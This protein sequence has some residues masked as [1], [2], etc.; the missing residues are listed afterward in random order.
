MKNYLRIIITVVVFLV[1]IRVVY[2]LLYKGRS[3]SYEIDDK[4]DVYEDYVKN[5]DLRY[6]YFEVT[7]SS[8]KFNFRTPAIFNDN[9]YVIKDIYYFNDDNY[10]CILPI[11]KGNSIQ[12][13]ILCHDGKIIQ[14]YTNLKNMNLKLD[15]FAREMEQYGYKIN[16]NE[17]MDVSNYGINLLENTVPSHTLLIP[18]YSGLFKINK[19]V[20]SS[21]DL[22]KKD[23]Y[24]QNIQGVVSN[25]Y[26]VADYDD[27]YSF[28]KFK[29][30]DIKTGKIT[31][32]G[33]KYSISMNS[34]VQGVVEN[35]LYI[36]DRSNRKQYVV[37]VL[38]KKVT[39]VGD[40]KKGVLYF[41]GN[42][43]ETKSIY[44]ALNDDVLF[45]SC[46][47]SSDYDYIYLIDNIY[48]SY[49]KVDN[50]Y[51]VY[52]SYAENKDLYTYIFSVDSIDR[53]QYIDNYVYY[54]FEDKLYC[55]H[56]KSGVYEILE[57]SE[58]FYNR[59]LKF[60]IYKK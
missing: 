23:V 16:N 15:E 20:I 54:V 13:D 17:D 33:S 48:Y 29:L 38:N 39:L 8:K 49:K 44:S 1:I 43:F 58:L 3:V 31:T 35:S 53:I 21:I 37:D 28:K 60:W 55:Y 2:L 25:Y 51:D 19:G 9:S 56:P 30:V 52:L 40:S 14:Q 59:N 50:G 4:F 42:D 6:Y 47:S 12:T 10:L 24:D 36:M 57:Y 18:S 45:S 27:S 26:V 22:F 5:N 32:L 11:F 34:Y 7:V 46:K 41:N